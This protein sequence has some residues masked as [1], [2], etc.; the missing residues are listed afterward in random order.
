MGFADECWWSRLAQPALHAWSA[1]DPLR[2]GQQTVAKDD[3]E[4]KAIACYGLLLRDGPSPDE[5][6]LRFVDGRPLSALTTQ[7]LEWGA[8]AWRRGASRR[9][10]SSGTTSPGM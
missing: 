1:G 9:C 3:P 6:W 4:P 2:L 10:S 5:L 8:S 7:C